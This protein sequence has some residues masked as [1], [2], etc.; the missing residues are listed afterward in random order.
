MK[1]KTFTIIELII[2]MTIVAVMFLMVKNIFTSENRIYY[3]GEICINSVYNQLKDIQQSALYSNVRSFSGVNGLTSYR[4]DWYSLIF[5]QPRL[6]WSA[7]TIKKADI[8]QLSGE[9]T[10]AF[11][12]HT[13][14]LV[15]NH[16]GIGQLNTDSI[17]STIAFARGTG[18]LTNAFKQTVFSLDIGYNFFRNLYLPFGSPVTF[19]TG[20]RG[21]A[22]AVV[23]AARQPVKGCALSEAFVSFYIPTTT[24]AQDNTPMLTVAFQNSYSNYPSKMLLKQSRE[25]DYD[26]IPGYSLT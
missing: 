5:L 10:A 3:E 16:P 15:W 6:D 4:P 17:F 14:N 19:I 18:E 9:V 11:A 21:A 1:K 7:G 22:A 20:N 24:P 25:S 26:Y 13:D 2:V 8:R 23:G 12:N